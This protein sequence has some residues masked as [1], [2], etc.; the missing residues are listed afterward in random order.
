MKWVEQEC[1]AV[2]DY[3]SIQGFGQAS[4]G[5]DYLFPEVRCSILDDEK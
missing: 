2:I 5:V 1:T 3:L 4:S